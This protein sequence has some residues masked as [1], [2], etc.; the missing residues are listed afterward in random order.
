[1]KI[2]N[3]KTFDYLDPISLSTY[4]SLIMYMNFVLIKSIK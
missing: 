3:L 4:K 2:E 1:M